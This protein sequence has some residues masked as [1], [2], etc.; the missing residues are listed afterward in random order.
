MSLSVLCGRSATFSKGPEFWGG[1]DFEP[2]EILAGD[3][4][5]V[6]CGDGI[7]RTDYVSGLGSNLLGYRH[8][9]Y[10]RRVAAQI[11]EGSGF[12]LPHKLE[13]RVAEKIANLIGS[14]VPGWATD[15]VGV[16]FG[17]SGSDGTSMA[18]RMARAVTRRSNILKARG[19]YHGWH[20]WTIGTDPP[21]WGIPPSRHVGRFTFGDLEDLALA[22][23][24]WA[25]VAAVIMEH[26]AQDPPPTWYAGV[27]RLCTD[28][29]ALLV[30]DE[31]VTSLRF[32]LAGVC[33]LYQVA[34][35]ICVLGKALANGLPLSCMVFRKEYSSWLSRGDPIFVSSTHFGNA[36][37][38]AAADAVLDIWD[39][40]CV[41]HLWEIGGGLMFG[42][43]EAGYTVIGQACRSLL[44]FASNA[45][46]GYFIAGMRD[47]GVLINRPNIPNLAH[48]LADVERT[49]AA[50]REVKAEM[51]RVDVAE[52]MR[53]KEPAVLFEGR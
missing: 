30:M 5:R 14:R 36:V 29:G 1:P 22:L 37:S 43:E 18:I 3:G 23:Q 38:L 46:R 20:E 42:L 32:D 53:G 12:S 11:W 16:R 26:P 15:S 33:G 17:L 49:V 13:R 25:P 35:D 10:C 50:A 47:R 34:A 31:V 9:E 48:T 52:V 51:E 8:P 19:A 21:A 45:E 24:Q 4:A 27:R 39:Q 7:W 28:Y 40:G 41:T 44:Q 2:T 6:L